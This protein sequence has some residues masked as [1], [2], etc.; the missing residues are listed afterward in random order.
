LY[1]RINVGKLVTSII[2]YIKPIAQYSPT[3]KR[4]E[5]GGWGTL[6]KK[7]EIIIV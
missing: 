4:V 6:K 3:V 5:P 1:L 7:L 2:R